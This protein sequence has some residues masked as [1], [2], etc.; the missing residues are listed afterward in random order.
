[1]VVKIK[2]LLTH[3]IKIDP[4]EIYSQKYDEWFDKNR[5]TYKSELQA[6]KEL[7]PKSKNAWEI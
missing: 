4:F 1:M 6:V 3:M 5:F 7:L 2:A